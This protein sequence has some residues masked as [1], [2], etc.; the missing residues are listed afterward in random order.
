MTKIGIVQ[1]MDRMLPLFGMSKFFD[2][3]GSDWRMLYW[4]DHLNDT[5][6]KNIHYQNLGKSFDYGQYGQRFKDVAWKKLDCDGNPIIERDDVDV[7]SWS[8]LNKTRSCPDYNRDYMDFHEIRVLN[9]TWHP[10][11]IKKEM[12]IIS[13][14]IKECDYIYVDLSDCFIHEEKDKILEIINGLQNQLCHEKTLFYIFDYASAYEFLGCN[15]RAKWN[16]E[17]EELKKE[18]NFFV[19]DSK[20]ILKKTNKSTDKISLQELMNRLRSLHNEM[21]KTIIAEKIKG[22]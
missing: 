20:K 9:D 10:I 6:L 15:I 14:W 17:I 13:E 7:D 5:V 21:V 19:Y 3:I 12:E 8:V 1:I 4:P 2:S 16:T 11:S 22:L 18:N